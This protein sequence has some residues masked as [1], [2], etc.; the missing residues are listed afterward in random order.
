VDAEAKLKE[1]LFNELVAAMRARLMSEECRAA[2]LNVVR[3]FL[4]DNDIGFAPQPKAG[5]PPGLSLVGRLPF[6][7]PEA[8]VG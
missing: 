4:K 3:Q 5:Q 7:P 2:D 6:A 8:D 1:E